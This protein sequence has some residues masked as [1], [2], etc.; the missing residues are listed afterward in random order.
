MRRSWTTPVLSLCLVALGVGVVLR[1]GMTRAWIEQVSS[2]LP[3]RPTQVRVWDWWSASTNE[4]YGAYFRDLEDTFEELHPDIDIVYQSVPFSNY[5]QKLSAAMVGPTP[6]DVFQSSIIWGEGSYRRG[7]LRPLNDLLAGDAHLPAAQRV[8]GGVF[9]PSAWRHNHTEDGV[10]FGIPQIIDAQCLVWN[11]DILQDAAADDESIRAVFSRLPDGTIDYDHIRYDAVED[12][13]H[14]RRIARR[15]TVYGPDGRVERGGFV[16]H[17]HGGGADLFS[18][19]LASNGGHYHDANGTRALFASPAG[20]QT[21]HFL[22]QLYWHDR[23]CPPFRRQ[24]SHRE[25]FEQRRAACVVAGTWS[26]KDIIRD[27]MGWQ[28]FG[29]TAFPPGPSGNGQRTLTWGNMLVITSRCQQVDAAWKYVRFVCSLEG[30]LLRSRH[31]GYNGPR[32]DF[33]DTAQWRRAVSERPYLSNVKEICLAGEKFR[34]TEITAADHQA[35]PV[36]EAILLRYP[37]ICAG[38]GPFPSV[39]DAMTLAAANVDSVYRRYN[40]QAESWETPGSPQTTGR[41]P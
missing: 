37:D 27:T 7:M 41:E 12:W 6:P 22:A 17:A 13:E 15:L 24:L 4:E 34:H 26:G 25:Y 16:I 30:N 5:V 33:Y 32:I 29:K 20:I 35:N 3:P 40:R 23:V 1:A 36:F 10:I 8:D 14:F 18:P 19:W 2:D 21:M 38:T 28:H 9:L 11:L 39:E 31:L